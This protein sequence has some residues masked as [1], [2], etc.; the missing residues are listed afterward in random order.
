[1][2]STFYQAITKLPRE[3]EE[4]LLQFNI[5]QLCALVSEKSGTA[6]R[7]ASDQYG[8]IQEIARRW[9]LD[10]LKRRIAMLEPE[11][12]VQTYARVMTALGGNPS[13]ETLQNHKAAAAREHDK[14]AKLHDQE[15]TR[16]RIASK[17]RPLE[18]DEVRA[19]LAACATVDDL[20]RV[21]KEQKLE[22]PWEKVESLANFGLMRMYIGNK[23][24]TK[25][26]HA[27]K[28]KT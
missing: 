23:W 27:T 22:I 25:I 7:G 8:P 12:P 14:D 3:V 21:A 9:E 20:K 17:L 18:Q 16:E 6:W 11:H 15:R 10:D 28:D 2:T 4:R 26:R 1:M 13:R 24:R 19:G 5:L